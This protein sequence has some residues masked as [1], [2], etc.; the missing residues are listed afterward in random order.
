VS[1]RLG[2][3]VYVLRT[4]D[5]GYNSGMDKAKGKSDSLAKSMF[6]AQLAYDLFKQSARAAIEIIKSSITEYA[7]HEKAVKQTETVLKSTSYA[8]GMSSKA[9]VDLSNSMSSLTGI[10]DD[11]ILEAENLLLTFTKIGKETFPQAIEMVSDMSVA[12]K[13]STSAMALMVGKLLNSSSAMGAAKKSGVSFTDQQMELGKQL[14]ETGHVAEYQA[15]VLKELQV[16]FGGSAR[17]ARDTFG[18]ALSNLKNQIGNVEEAFGMY[19]A[20]AGRPFVENMANMAEG[21]EKWLVSSEGM[22]VVTD[23][24]S[25][26]GGYLI[27][28]GAG[29]KIFV[30]ELSSIGTST[31]DSV[32]KSLQTF[33]TSGKEL[34]PI[35]LGVAA[36]M[37]VLFLKIQVI[38]T[39][40]KIFAAIISGV[41]DSV[42]LLSGDVQKKIDAAQA[43]ALAANNEIL[44]QLQAKRDLGQKVTAEE[45]ANAAKL[46]KANN[47]VAESII[48]YYDA[49]PDRY[50]KAI[51]TSIGDLV[52]KAF[53]SGDDIEK[54]MNEM[55]DAFQKGSEGIKESLK[56]VQTELSDTVGE[57]KTLGER[58]KD[59]YTAMTTPKE[60]KP[61]DLKGFKEEFDTA[62]SEIAEDTKKITDEFAEAWEAASEK[63]IG[64]LVGMYRA[65][66]DAFMQ[67]LENDQTL[68]DNDYE[69][70]KDYINANVTDEKERTAQ[71]EILEKE[72]AKKTAEIKKK[73]FIAQ[74]DADI[75]G[76]AISTIRGV[77][78]AIAMAN[79]FPFNFV[80][81]G[82][83]AAAGVVQAANIMSQPIPEFAGGG[84]FTTAGP[85]L[86]M[87][88]D[89][90]GG[91]E[92]V[93]IDPINNGSS[94]NSQ[95]V[96]VIINLDGRALYDGIE[97]ASDDGRLSLNMRALK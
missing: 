32:S 26:L 53:S 9:I 20:T 10:E 58:F 35:F 59:W 8:A 45:M 88:G 4:D 18:G 76:L 69:R 90:P 72:H 44:Q 73:Q 43:K 19:M 47:A 91:R 93:R 80:L 12:L 83:I 67:S 38:T 15:M 46:M 94:N 51:S 52:G 6:S 70:K 30:S 96:H 16:E 75:I 7:A 23:V 85:Q 49:A 33:G 31:F 42:D 64:A 86:I 89:N 5:Q 55:N 54:M 2:D 60:F 27:A 82:L 39:A 3:A 62:M 77:G 21:V 13:S 87:V 57:T 74:R 79:L 68:E 48:A 11:T 24:L 22:K 92:H 56:G 65:I 66:S 29:I 95:M 84:D 28:A 1:E 97:K 37:Q 41:K 14:F 36:I 78:E 71:L 81:A 50:F 61:L 63:I 40:I 34:N 25:T 17:A